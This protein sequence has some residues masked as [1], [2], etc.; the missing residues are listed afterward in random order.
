[1]LAK[2]KTTTGV[3]IIL[4]L[5]LQIAGRVVAMQGP[6]LAYAGLGVTLVGLIVFVFGCISYAKGKGHSQWW[7]LLGLF[8]IFGLIVLAF[9]TD[10]HRP[11]GTLSRRPAAA[12]SSP[13]R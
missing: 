7:G 3:G 11:M 12:R 10:R 2:Y 8:S 4:G 6:A 5:L 9:F 1:M 13:T